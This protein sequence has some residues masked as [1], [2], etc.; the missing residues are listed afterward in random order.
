MASVQKYKAA[1]GIRWRVQYRSPD[2]KS[3]TKQGFTHKYEA[4]NW[5][6]KNTVH[7]YEQDWIDPTGGKALISDVGERWITA[8]THLKP[9]T[10]NLAHDVWN[11][12]VKPYWGA[13]PVAS[14]KQSD[15]QHWVSN[16]GKSAS[17]TRHA[18]GQLSQIL[19]YAIADR[20]IRVNPARGVKLPKKLKSVKVFWT[21]E[22][23]EYF[24]SL[25]GMRE[26]LVLL[27]GTSGLRWGEAVALRKKDIDFNR[28]RINI[29]RNAAKVGNKIVL[30]SPKT[31]ENRSVA[32][33]QHVLN[34]ITAHTEHLSDDAL[35]WEAPRG[36]YLMA[37]GHDSWFDSAMRKT[38]VVRPVERITAHGLRHVAAGLLVQSGAN[39]KAV[40]RQ[41]G[42]ASAVMTL[43]TYA[44]L[45]DD[46]LDGIMQVLDEGFGRGNVV[47]SAI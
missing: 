34:K 6:A 40:Q 26:S 19:D 37:P 18:H 9:S 17:W 11:G 38:M 27:L 31:H 33:A 39:V 4:E 3:R 46:G 24:A 28:Q 23:L 47:E 2:G 5:A 13:R 32:V 10:L 25:C 44:E 15:I 21:L 42:H 7:I 12:T 16:T 20:L 30:G 36:G 45:F 29:T 22:D 43:D 35:I 14:V 1:K 41:L 8:Q